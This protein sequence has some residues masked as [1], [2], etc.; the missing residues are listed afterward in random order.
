[1]AVVVTGGLV[2]LVG[3]KTLMVVLPGLAQTPPPKSE[4][5]GQCSCLLAPSSVAF[6][7]TGVSAAVRW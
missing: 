3:E 6:T 1:M 5:C 7:P 4:A 2:G